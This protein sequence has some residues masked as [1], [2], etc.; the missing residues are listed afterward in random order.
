M[1]QWGSYWRSGDR[2]GR[3]ISFYAKSKRCA[4]NL[5]VRL[6]AAIQGDEI[7]VWDELSNLVLFLLL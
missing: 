5:R 3:Y 1:P 2:E 4:G 7:R 6:L